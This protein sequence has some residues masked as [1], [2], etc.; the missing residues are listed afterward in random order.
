MWS[1]SVPFAVDTD[2]ADGT[3][4]VRL[5]GELDLATRSALWDQLADVAEKKPDVL[6][7]DLGGVTFL[8][9]GTAVMMI[10]MNRL[11]T[12][13]RKTILR[14]VRPQARRLLELTGLDSHCELA[15]DPSDGSWVAARVRTRAAAMDAFHPL[16]DPQPG[17]LPAGQQ[18][19]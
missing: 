9:C 15:D 19:P 4:V 5:H 13:G 7:I 18:L 14:S 8:D 12:S 10:K 11:L 2:M 16:G 3:A 1:G 6:I 17:Y